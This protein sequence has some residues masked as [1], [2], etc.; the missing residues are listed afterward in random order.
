M[1]VEGRAREYRGTSPTPTEDEV[2]KTIERYTA[3]VPS[4]ALLAVALGAIGLSLM[5]QLGGRGK[6]GNFIAQWVPT[7]LIMGVYNKLV[8]TAGHDQQDRGAGRREQ[9]AG[10][11][12]R[13]MGEERVAQSHVPP[14]GQAGGA[15]VVG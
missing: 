3:M 11:S 4:S 6:W 7:L 1:D 12:N 13:S 15:R 2:T 5:S 14:R 8:K 9:A 10:I